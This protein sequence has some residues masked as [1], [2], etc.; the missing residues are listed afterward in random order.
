MDVKKLR[1]CP[2][3]LPEKFHLESIAEGVR[4]KFCIIE[5]A[6]NVK[7]PKSLIGS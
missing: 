3:I 2:V 4:I 5:F 7:N 1:V 6:I